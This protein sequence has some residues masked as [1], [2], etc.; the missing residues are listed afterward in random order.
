MNVRRLPH[1]LRVGLAAFLGAQ[2]A[3]VIGV[4]AVDSYRKR[5]RELTGYPHLAPQTT[6]L[7]DG[8]LTVYTYGHDLY[9]AML[10]AISGAQHHI[11]SEPNI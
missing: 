6:E 1:Y 5:G 10:E 7:D 2:A 4:S 9:D 11:S 3:A 8:D